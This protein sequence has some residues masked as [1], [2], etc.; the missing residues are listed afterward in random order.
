MNESLFMD[1]VG[2]ID[3]TLLDEH[4]RRRDVLTVRLAA[5]K[6]RKRRRISALV[7]CLA[8]V[9]L[10]LYSLQYIPEECGI[11]VT[12]PAYDKNGYEDYFGGTST[13][14][15]Y[16]VNDW[17]LIVRQR[18]KVQGDL[19]WFEVWKHYNGVGDE[20][21]MIDST[22]TGDI[23]IYNHKGEIQGWRTGDYY[24]WTLTV[25]SNITQYPEHEKLLQSIKKTINAISDV[26]E[27]H[28]VIE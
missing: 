1:A 12:D 18:V 3:D 7:A 13:Y 20:V 23:P 11:I 9:M 14:W 10:G 15:V 8:V 27:I 6:K 17:G 16:Y 2:K 24:V 28:V 19:H 21:V 26:D 22:I 5:R 4:L 25:S